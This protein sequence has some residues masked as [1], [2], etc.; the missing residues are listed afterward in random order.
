MK[1]DHSKAT[2]RF[3]PECGITI[4]SVAKLPRAL[5]IH[6][7]NSQKSAE[8]AA[9]HLK[10]VARMDGRESR[11][12]RQSESRAIAAAK[13]KAWAGGVEAKMDAE[14]KNK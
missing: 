6:L 3:C 12:R 13:Y 5:L 14:A 2:S 11:F 7:R 10:I 4:V 9:K 8:T 1:C